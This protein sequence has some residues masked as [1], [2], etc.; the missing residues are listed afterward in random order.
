MFEKLREALQGYKTYIIAVIAVFSAILA[1]TNGQASFF[2]AVNAIL[3]ATG[4]G[5]LRSGVANLGKE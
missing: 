5:T 3:L 1:F 4:L 2:E